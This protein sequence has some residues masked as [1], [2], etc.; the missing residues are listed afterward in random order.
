MKNSKIFPLFSQC[1]HQVKPQQMTVHIIAHHC[2]T[3]MQLVYKHLTDWISFSY[4]LDWIKGVGE[5]ILKAKGI[6][7]EDYANDITSGTIPLDELGIL[8]ISRMYHIHIGI[9]LKDRVWF[10][11]SKNDSDNCLF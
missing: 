7:I 4:H 2:K 1:M 9:V 5:K 3:T 11:N 8:V 10:T 6:H